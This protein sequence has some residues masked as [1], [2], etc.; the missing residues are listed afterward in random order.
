MNAREE[1]IRSYNEKE[2]NL[3]ET[4]EK[5]KGVTKNLRMELRAIKNYARTLKY[6]AEDWAPVGIPLPEILKKNP[7][8]KLDDDNVSGFVRNQV[9]FKFFLNLNKILINK[10]MKIMRN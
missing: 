8:V 2:I 1:L 10:R 5:E 9:N 6:L 7:P 3:N 4:I